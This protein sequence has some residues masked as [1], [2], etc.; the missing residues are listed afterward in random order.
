MKQWV[1]ADEIIDR[2]F[3]GTASRIQG[4]GF[5]ALIE[6]ARRRHKF[7]YPDRDSDR[8]PVLNNPGDFHWAYWGRIPH[9]EPQYHIQ[10]ATRRQEQ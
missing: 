9:V 1:L 7:A 2:C 8:I 3:V 4:V 5:K 10:P 6:E